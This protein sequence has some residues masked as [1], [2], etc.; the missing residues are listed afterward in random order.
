MPE[1]SIKKP[2]H[3][4]RFVDGQPTVVF[5]TICTKNK[6]AW[7]ASTS[8]HKLLVEVWQ[9]ADL[10]LVGRYVIMPDHIHLFAWATEKAIDYENWVRYWKSQFTKQ[11]KV[12]SHRWQA[13]HWDTRM[14]SEAVYEEKWNYV[15]QN[16]KRAQL[17]N[18]EQAWP[19]Q[20]EVYDLRWF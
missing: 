10:W 2:A 17:V 16:P 15:K 9:N 13:D 8:V 19:Y 18:V 5:D 12:P 1:F 11:H 7:L 3:G 6:I 14:R 20:G 4:V